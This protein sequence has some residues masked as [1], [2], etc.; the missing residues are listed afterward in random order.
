MPHFFGAAAVETQACALKNWMR[1]LAHG[2]DGHG[3]GWGEESAGLTGYVDKLQARKVG[4]HGRVSRETKAKKQ[5]M[6]NFKTGP[7]SKDRIMCAFPFPLL[8][9]V[10][11]MQQPL[12]P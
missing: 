11:L 1:C 10:V 8:Q 3:G 6:D 9:N 12:A 4:E 7:Q 2:A 5:I